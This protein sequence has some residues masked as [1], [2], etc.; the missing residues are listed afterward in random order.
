MSHTHGDSCLCVL[1]KVWACV[2]LCVC[3]C[4]SSLASR[5]V[6]CDAHSNVLSVPPTR[7][8]RLLFDYISY[9]PLYVLFVRWDVHGESGES[10]CG[11]T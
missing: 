3:V 2:C 9:F 7:P 11:M 5:R 1:G 4:V 6:C 8:L 10:G